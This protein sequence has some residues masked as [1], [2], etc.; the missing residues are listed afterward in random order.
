MSKSEAYKINIHGM[1][2]QAVFW[3]GF[4]TYVSFMIATL[5]DYGWAANTAA[6]AITAMSVIV[7]F[8]Q[9]IY[10]YITDRYLSEKKLSI[11]L[12]VLTTILLVL[13]PFSLRFGNH[14]MVLMNMVGISVTGMQIAGLMDAWVVGLKQEIETVNYGLIRGAGSL[15][16]ALSA[17]IAGVVTIYFGHSARLWIGSGFL[18]LA[19]FVALSFR[20]ARRFNQNGEKKKSQLGGLETLKLIFSSKQYCLLLGVAFFLILSSASMSMI[21]QLLIPEFGGSTAQIGSAFAFKAGSEV[22]FMFLMAFFL[23]KIGFKKLLFFCSAVFVIRMFITMSVGTVNGLIYVQLL[24][25]LTFAILLPASMG[26]LSQIIDERVRATA[27]TIFSAI[28]TSFTVIIGNLIISLLLTM[29]FAA[30]VALNIFVFTALIG[31]T[32]T[33]YGMIRKLWDANKASNKHNDAY[34]G[35]C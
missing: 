13:L 35:D 8:T 27:V 7:V 11:L 31:F 1:L 6:G 10:G 12:L 15:A 24:Q 26:Y 28:I 29:G 19:V 21:L 4:C 16:F 14:L 30:Q 20:P 5:I 9:P 3:L 2:Y 17:Q 18:M 32:L 34:E 22:P 25:G 23:K 33:I